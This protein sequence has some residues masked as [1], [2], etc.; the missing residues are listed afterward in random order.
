MKH[1]KKPKTKNNTKP[2][3][4]KQKQNKKQIK[5]HTQPIQNSHNT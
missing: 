4:K 2:V 3:K 5:N 1:N